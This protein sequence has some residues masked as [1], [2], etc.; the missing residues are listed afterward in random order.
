MQTIPSSQGREPGTSALRHSMERIVPMRKLLGAIAG[1]FLY[2][3]MLFLLISAAFCQQQCNP[4]QTNISSVT[5]STWMPGQTYHIVI[6]GQY[7]TGW[8]PNIECQI[9]DG[10]AL[11]IG[12]AND[13]WSSSGAIGD[14]ET[15]PGPGGQDGVMSVGFGKASMQTWTN[16]QITATVKLNAGVLTQT[17]CLY[18]MFADGDNWSLWTP[19]MTPSLC[20]ATGGFPIQIGCPT[21]IIV[22][23]SPRTWFA[24]ETYDK[25]VIITGTGF[26]TQTASAHSGC[27]VT[28]VTIAAADGTSVAVGSVKVDSDTKITLNGIA[29]PDDLKTQS[30]TLTAG[31]APNAGTFS[32]LDIL[33]APQIV[34]TGVAMQCNGMTISGASAYLQTVVVG[35]NINKNGKT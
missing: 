24:G 14:W 3:S 23:V 1:P 33:G 26:V 29:P 11:E 34:C 2:L 32:T 20:S 7:L 27:P 25:D 22:S 10:F 31:T 30:A 13:D 9:G 6:L 28:P 15:V 5:P 35:Q 21:P 16:T 8:D 4:Y 18:T 12:D 17:A 19:P